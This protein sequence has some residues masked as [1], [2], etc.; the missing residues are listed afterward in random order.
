M[1]V[2]IYYT[3]KRDRPLSAEEHVRIHCVV[4][5]YAVEDQIDRY[6]ASGQGPNWQSFFV[7][8]SSDPSE[9]GVIF[10][11]A[12]G[13]PDN[14]EDAIRAGVQHWCAALSA[15]RRVVPDAEW[16]VYIE[17]CAIRWDQ[18][19]QHFDPWT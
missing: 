4:D 6:L 5:N 7:Y 13:L 3:A 12:T 9:P 16:R 17:D 18:R 1:G 15:I 19:K 14:S 8:D 11:G 2:S 10:E